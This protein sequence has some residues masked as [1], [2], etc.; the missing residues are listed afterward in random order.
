MKHLFSPEGRHALEDV[1]QHQPLLAFD[2]DGTLAPIV[3]RPDDARVP[4]PLARR[5]AQLAQLRPVAV[6]TGRRIADVVERL[7]FVPHYLVGNH[8]AEDPARP[9]DPHALAAM[10]HLRRLLDER[11]P[12]LQA[13]GVRVEDKGLSVALHYRLAAD[14]A[15]AQTAID[16][17]LAALDPALERFGGKCVVNVVPA[18]VPDKG[19]A[20]T[21]LQERSGAGAVVFIGDDVNDESVFRLAGEHWLTVRIGRDD[22]QSSARFFLDSQAEVAT[23][24][25]DMLERLLAQG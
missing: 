21:A 14:R 9:A 11:A 17:A 15:H 7:G 10:D 16:D 12:A 3:A 20:V 25:Q 24:L 6:V 4:V 8:G 23:L 5:L 1:L 2:F 18:G 22:P 13:A 19:E